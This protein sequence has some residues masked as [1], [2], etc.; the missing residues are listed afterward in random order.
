MYPGLED[1]YNSGENLVP[2]LEESQG[3]QVERQQENAISNE[4]RLGYSAYKVMLISKANIY[5]VLMNELPGLVLDS[6]YYYYYYRGYVDS[7]ELYVGYSY[8]G[9]CELCLIHL[10]SQQPR[11]RYQYY[12]ITNEFTEAQKNANNLF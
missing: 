4:H 11:G 8:A 5:W 3:L 2:A 1:P 10:L 6:L 9:Y 7:Y 12:L